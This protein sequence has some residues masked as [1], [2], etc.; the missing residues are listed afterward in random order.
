MKS[1]LNGVFAGAFAA[2][3]IGGAALA[4][5]PAAPAPFAPGMPVG[6]RT[7][8]FYMP[9][10]SNVRVFGGAVNAESCVY[11]DTRSLIVVINRGANQDQAPNDGYVSLLNSDGTV[12]TP[13]WIG[14]TRNGLVLN[15]P[16][17]SEIFNGKLYLLDR[18]GGTAD[19][20]PSISVIRM[21]DMLTA[22]PAGEI[23]VP[24]SSGFNDLGI[25]AD[26]TIYASQTGNATTPMR[27]YKITPAGQSSVF[28]DGG[29]LKSPNGVAVDNDGNIVVLN[30]GSDEVLTFSPAAQ[31]IKTEKAGQPG[32]DGIV[33]MKDGTKYISSVQQ[34]G[35]SRIRPG[36]AA[37][38]IATGIPSAASMCHD[39]KGNQLVVPMN[40]N[41]GVAFVRLPAN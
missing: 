8:G 24:D 10:S 12:H 32:S 20:A 21:F 35:I 23:R 34:G 19:G 30:M 9:A 13:R 6:V 40:P 38:L 7:D 5:Q 14:A 31:L 26:G 37:E 17:G 4:Q 16:F 28:I 15:H 22:A 27:I 2:V 18:D 39:P 3:V 36:A 1:L 25:A 33:I 11:D 29:P 41:N